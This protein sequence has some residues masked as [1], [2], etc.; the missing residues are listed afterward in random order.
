M[1]RSGTG[2]DI[3]YLQ[4]PSLLVSKDFVTRPIPI[5]EQDLHLNDMKQW[6]CG[7]FQLC[8]CDG[9]PINQPLIHALFF[10]NLLTVT[11]WIATGE[12]NKDGIFHTHVMF[13]TNVRSDSL[14]RSC[15]TQ[16][17][18]LTITDS[19]TKRYGQ[20][21][22]LECIKLQRCHKPSSLLG[23]IMKKPE[24]VLSNSERLLQL[25][26]DIDTW[27]MNDRFKHREEPET[28]PEINKMTKE[29]LDIIITNQ[30]KTLEDCL[31]GN[32]EIMSKYL[33]KPG[34]QSIVNNC[35]AFVKATGGNW[36][37]HLF[38]QYDPNPEP[39]HR[40][41]LHQGIPPSI[42]D[43]IFHTWI[44]KA[45]SKKNTICIQG[46]SNTGKSAFIA[47]LKMTCPWGE[48]VNTPTFAFEGLLET[49]IGVWEE[50]LCSPELAEKAKQVLEGMP[51]AI[52][53]KYRK[54]QILNR[55]P[56]IITTNHDLW[57]FCTAEEDMF[58]NRMWIFKFN[59][60]C[61]DVNYYPRISEPSCG[62]RY[63]TGSRGGPT[64]HGS[65]SPS[66]MQ[67]TEQSI[68]PREQ[69]IRSD[70]ESD[71]G[72]GSLSDPGEGTSSSHYGSRSSSST[73]SKKQCSD[74][75]RST[76]S[77]STTT[78]FH[79][80]REQSR[81]INPRD[82]IPSTQSS[83]IQYVESKQHPRND[84]HDSS[85]NGNRPRKS[86]TK[87]RGGNGASIRESSATSAV[88]FVEKTTKTKKTL[89]L[90]S[91][92]SK[93]DREMGAITGLTKIP[94]Y[95]PLKQDWCEYLSWIFH[96]YG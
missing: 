95:V 23:Y 3:N 35:L 61:K 57:R 38:Q 86:T 91:K 40:C 36:G 2:G 7:I 82:R 13:K 96:Q 63:C 6:Q 25:A 50:P 4:A 43:P 89:P 24:W 22:Q 58:R 26:S 32:P 44:T 39:I 11:D 62:C 69:S 20:D 28:D 16:W 93:L 73:S 1:G 42:F 14:R 66:R 71:V 8:D 49:V 87:R 5:V 67:T 84:E 90:P 94:M 27:G 15:L 18:N 31:R 74:S 55:T 47:G 56:I 29:I 75:S 34:L 9:T 51:C 80:G 21:C 33:H 76:I 19:F 72:P 45:D 88:G 59:H 54:P 83:I 77:T 60:P 30:C 37:I 70:S 12:E 79:V 65:T 53:V 41:L 81:S 52:A 10:N 68:S 46:P 48:I 17:Q 85:R 78:E 92:K 64:T